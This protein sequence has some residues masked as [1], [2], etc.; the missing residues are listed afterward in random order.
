MREAIVTVEVDTS[1]GL[2]A[3]EPLS[4]PGVIVVLALQNVIGRLEESLLDVKNTID[5]E[6]RHDV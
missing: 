5:I 1:V 3:A 4:T 2:I 6:H